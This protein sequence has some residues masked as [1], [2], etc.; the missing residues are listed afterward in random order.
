LNRTDAA[1]LTQATQ[2]TGDFETAHQQEV[3]VSVR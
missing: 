1:A 3:M 2:P